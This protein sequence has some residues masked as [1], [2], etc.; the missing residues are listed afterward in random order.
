MGAV[1]GTKEEVFPRSGKEGQAEE[2]PLGWAWTCESIC[3][4]QWSTPR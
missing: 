4:T 2:V 1:G 3:G